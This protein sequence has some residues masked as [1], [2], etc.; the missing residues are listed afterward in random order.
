[1]ER[2]SD[3]TNCGTSSGHDRRTDNGHQR[4][5]ASVQPADSAPVRTG[6]ITQSISVCGLA[7]AEAVI[8]FIGVSL[9]SDA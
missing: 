5:I 9:P 2:N 1:M 7:E 8:A 4:L 3:H 6:R